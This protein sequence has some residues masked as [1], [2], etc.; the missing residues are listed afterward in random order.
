M[1]PGIRSAR[2]LLLFGF[3]LLHSVVSATPMLWQVR[4]SQTF[5]VMGTIHLPDPRV[6]TLPDSVNKLFEHITAVYTE[7][8][9]DAQA[10]Q[11]M[12]AAATLPKGQSLQKLLPEPLARR[13]DRILGDMRP[14]LTLELFSNQKIWVLAVSLSVLQ[15]QLDHPN[16]LPQDQ[17]LY[18]RAVKAGKRVGGIETDQEQLAI[19]EE[20]ST[21]EQLKLL[22]DTVE[23]IEQAKQ[24]NRDVLSEML[25][26]YLEGNLDR[27][28][29]IM[30]AYTKDEPFYDTFMERIL[31]QRN[32]TMADRM[33]SIAL[34][35]PDERILFAIGSGHLAGDYGVLTLLE[36]LG[37]Q[38]RR[39]QK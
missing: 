18:Q 5:Y 30:L 9:L 34:Q 25:D 16:E 15:Y 17:M 31:T 26:A 8:E 10:G 37:Y 20:L 1:M 22:E 4:G 33:T 11:R 19:F 3:I 36:Q 24:E 28:V 39:L 23:F 29:A 21:Q 27:L 32:F 35:H 14:P 6:T 38:V 12:A 2:V 7:V 13:V